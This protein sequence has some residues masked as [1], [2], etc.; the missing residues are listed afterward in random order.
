[1]PI[2]SKTDSLS[3]SSSSSSS[4]QHQH[5]NQ[6]FH[7][8]TSACCGAENSKLAAERSAIDNSM[9]CTLRRGRPNTPKTGLSVDYRIRK[10]SVPNT[11]E[12]THL[13]SSRVNHTISSDDYK[14]IS[15][16]DLKKNLNSYLQQQHASNTKIMGAKQL[17]SKSNVVVNLSTSSLNTAMVAD[18][19]L[20]GSRSNLKSTTA[21]DTTS[22]NESATSRLLDMAFNEDD[23]EDSDLEDNNESKNPS[24]I[25]TTTTTS[26]CSLSK[27]QK[28]RR[29]LSKSLS[30][31][32]LPD[33]SSANR[34]PDSSPINTTSVS[35]SSTYPV[36]K[37]SI[38][39]DSLPEAVK[40][41]DID[42][43]DYH[44]EGEHADEKRN[45]MN[46]N[47]NL[48][49]AISLDE[50]PLS[51]TELISENRKTTKNKDEAVSVVIDNKSSKEALV[52]PVAGSEPKLGE[53][54][55][56]FKIPESLEDDEDNMLQ[57][58]LRR[59]SLFKL[60]E[61]I[62]GK[63]SKQISEIEQRKLSPY[64]FSNSPLKQKKS[65]EHG[66]SNL[67]SKQTVMKRCS[68]LPV[69]KLT[70]IPEEQYVVKSSDK[71]STT[72]ATSTIKE[73]ESEHVKSSFV[74]NPGKKFD[75]PFRKI[76][77]NQTTTNV[78]SSPFRAAANKFFYKKF[79]RNRNV[80][81]LNATTQATGS[82]FTEDTENCPNR[83]LQVNS[84]T[85]KRLVSDWKCSN[86][87]VNL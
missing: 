36:I 22:L 28:S 23:I 12:C 8:H 84:P 1:M 62:N 40:S 43:H 39:S 77:Q 5:Q 83:S 74:S 13:I 46:S 81:R 38:S 76:D 54:T 85:G 35:D 17:K 64:R 6:K 79:N 30:L 73:T 69:S 42:E 72:I 59:Q 71:L 49:K 70:E 4:E 20:T 80:K 19:D 63:V 2:K 75:K 87:T 57:N 15:G 11:P 86:E 41:K 16:E 50:K 51:K 21:A 37:K 55:F 7:N 48:M 34:M 58:V 45:E 60:K 82:P 65:K 67:I 53:E 52:T 68:D 18:D 29:K 78:I 10:S 66:T 31:S 32:N 3:S 44:S 33:S 47:E 9:R 61:K 27:A 56:K 24:N 25:T 14:L 26:S